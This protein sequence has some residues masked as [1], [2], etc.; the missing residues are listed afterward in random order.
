MTTTKPTTPIIRQQDSLLIVCRAILPVLDG[1]PLPLIMT[2]TSRST[3]GII[4]KERLGIHVWNAIP[5]QTILE[6]LIVFVVIETTTTLAKE[7][8]D[9]M[10]VI[11]TGDPNRR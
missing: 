5:H 3:Q 8:N 4:V 6:F 7:I 2:I 11:L 1:A 10:N 9:V